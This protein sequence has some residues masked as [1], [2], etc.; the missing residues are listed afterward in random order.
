MAAKRTEL[1]RL[2]DKLLGALR[3]AAKV[4]SADPEAVLAASSGRTHLEGLVPK[5]AANFVKAAMNHPGIA[6][7]ASV[8]PGLAAL[9]VVSQDAAALA[10]RNPSLARLAVLSPEAAA[11]AE[12]SPELAA[13]ART[14]PEVAILSARA[15]SQTSGLRKKSARTAKRKPR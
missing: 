5:S 13:I 9:S 7:L 2:A 4:E 12:I 11:M 8:S 14:S 10:L 15:I 1:A 6:A 3:K